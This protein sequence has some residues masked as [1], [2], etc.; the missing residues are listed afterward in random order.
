MIPNEQQKQVIDHGDGPCV[1]VAVPGSG[2]TACVTER[3]KRLVKSG[4][5]PSLIL[6]ITF[7]NKA[8]E[9]M[10]KRIGLSVGEDAASKMTISTFHAL[11]VRILRKYAP[12]VNLTNRF[13]VY[14]AD[15][16]ER[17]AKQCVREVLI[18]PAPPKDKQ[19]DVFAI[20]E[21]KVEGFLPKKFSS[22]DLPKDYKFDMKAFCSKVLQ[23]VELE[24]N[25]M[26]LPAD[27]DKKLS[28]DASER[29]MVDLYY[30]TLDANNAIDFTG[31]ISKVVQLLGSNTGVREAMRSRWKYIC[32]DE[33]QDTNIAQYELIKMIGMGHCN[34]MVV[35]DA[36]Q[37]IYRFRSAM[38]ENVIKFRDE[39]GAKV[40]KLEKN[41]RSTPSILRHAQK[42]IEHNRSRIETELVTDNL[43]GK[44]PIID[45]HDSE[46]RMANSIAHGIVKQIDKGT[47]H[48][49]I[50]VLFR[51]NASSRSLEMSM[52][53][54]NIPYKLVGS[55]SFYDRKEIKAAMAGLTLFSNPL[56]TNSF[57]KVAE[58]CCKGVGDKILARINQVRKER[59]VDVIQAA[60]DVA[61]SGKA[62]S[63][64]I[65]ISSLEDASK[66]SPGQALIEMLGK[67]GF[68]EKMSRESTHSNDRVENIRELCVDV[69][70]Y[71]SK[72]N[73]LAGYLQNV[74]LSSS[75]D[76]VEGDD[77]VRLMTM[78]ASKGL[79]FDAVFISHAGATMLPHYRIKNEPDLAEREY[80]VEEERRLLYVAMTR[81]RLFLAIHYSLTRRGFGGH[82]TNE[83]PSPFLYETGIK[84]APT[85][86]R[87]PAKKK[88]SSA[89]EDDANERFDSVS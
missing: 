6:A 73:T 31:M 77:K 52:K 26:L 30:E 82:V 53:A 22:H 51:T 24:R 38:P 87:S 1:V 79:E 54:K 19:E 2:K 23:R 34:V 65:M 32:V 4:V 47:P 9:E 12:L 63:L 57:E 8:A 61:A 5:D 7:T 55:L 33:I 27:A 69:D 59:H 78:H 56:D 84:M 17:I 71:V 20:P 68:L 37:S 3:I 50:A 89:A 58:Q 60:K 39:F 85:P 14:D 41:Y 35:G 49:E 76:D 18:P 40:L 15:D 10:R 16:Q 43:D 29:K 48:S 44:P 74:A 13:T 83:D 21:D 46:D 42:L 11:C 66:C 64:G 25:S 45:Q 72:G 70:E 80:Q 86:L 67:L 88:H 75:Q 62:G 81:A 36:D 28:L